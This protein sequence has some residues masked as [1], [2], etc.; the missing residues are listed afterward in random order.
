VF[1]AFGQQNTSGGGHKDFHENLNGGIIL[2]AAVPQ[3]KRTAPRISNQLNNEAWRH[4][5]SS[6]NA[7]TGGNHRHPFIAA[8][9]LNL[10]AV[11]A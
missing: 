9:L 11:I 8:R 7:Q 5:E 6:P 1:P 3:K 2:G 10:K 4:C